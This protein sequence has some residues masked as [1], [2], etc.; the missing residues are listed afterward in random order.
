MAA[1]LEHGLLININCIVLLHQFVK[2]TEPNM[3][4]SYWTDMVIQNALITPY[5]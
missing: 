4:L 2:T 5:S 3:I 1:I